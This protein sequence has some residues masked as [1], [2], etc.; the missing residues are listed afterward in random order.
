MIQA[1]VDKGN[2]AAEEQKA[3]ELFAWLRK[4]EKFGIREPPADLEVN[5]API[6]NDPLDFGEKLTIHRPKPAAEHTSSMEPAESPSGDIPNDDGTEPQDNTAANEKEECNYNLS[7][8]K[9]G[10]IPANVA[11]DSKPQN[12]A[13]DAVLA[14]GEDS[15]L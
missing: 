8:S 9:E 10:G 3:W 1:A 14:S 6:R 5:A 4:R 7:S 13:M 11:D 15:S 12:I 2:S